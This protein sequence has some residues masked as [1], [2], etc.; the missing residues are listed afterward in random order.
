MS[1]IHA[2]ATARV[3]ADGSTISSA[4]S[5]PNAPK[6]EEVF[7]IPAGSTEK[8]ELKKEEALHAQLEREKVA[9]EKKL[10]ASRSRMDSLRQMQK[11]GVLASLLALDGAGRASSAKDAVRSGSPRRSSSPLRRLSFSRE[12]R[13]ENE[14]RKESEPRKPRGMN[15][16]APRRSVKPLESLQQSLSRSCSPSTRRALV[17]PASQGI[18]KPP[19]VA[20]APV[21]PGA[22]QCVSPN[23]GD[24]PD[25]FAA[26]AALL[27]NG[28]TALRGVAAAPVVPG[29]GLFAPPAAQGVDLHRAG[30]A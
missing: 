19:A 9:L 3:F 4:I 30:G 6:T 11:A 24:S 2:T 26:L 23:A 10:A 25:P 21:V 13:K 15:G 7:S 27:D 29:A 22:G 18:D 20:A 12:P 17:A 14:P 8:E 5:L 16:P 1:S 28:Q